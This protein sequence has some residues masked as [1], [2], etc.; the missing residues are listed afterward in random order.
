[1]NDEPKSISIR[2]FRE[3][4]FLQELNRGFL[5]PHGLAL[6]VIVHDGGREEFGPIWDYRDDPDGMRFSIS[7]Q[8]EP[9]FREKAERIARLREERRAAREETCGYW[10]QPI[11]VQP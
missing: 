10:I 5:H 11:E 4:G 3:L 1:M 9:E 7:E 6:S 8:E 2:E